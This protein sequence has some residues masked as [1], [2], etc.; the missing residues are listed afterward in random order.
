MV[1]GAEAGCLRPDDQGL[2][3]KKTHV[4]LTTNTA[5]NKTMTNFKAG[6]A[7][8]VAL[9][10]QTG[11]AAQSTETILLTDIT[12]D[13]ICPHDWANG[14]TEFGGNGPEIYL[15]VY[16]YPSETDYRALMARIVFSAKE[17]GGDYSE[18]QTVV[19]RTVYYGPPGCKKIAYVKGED[20]EK[21]SLVLSGGGRNEMFQ[22][23]DG[24]QHYLDING[25]LI[26]RVIM[27]GDTGG[28]DISTDDNCHCD[29]RIDRIELQ[30]FEL[31]LRKH[32]CD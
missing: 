26:K 19:N 23:C 10:L 5:M 14:D 32:K 9:T 24:D 4:H 8:L 2:C 25:P 3:T 13:D 20:V 17:T 18:V 22:G 6:V 29:T 30:P 12:I 11:L 7:L 21:L 1:W 15:S 27:V 16:L 31:V 28:A